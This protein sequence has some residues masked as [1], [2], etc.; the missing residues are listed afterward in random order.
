[1]TALTFRPY[2]GCLDVTLGSIR[3]AVQAV[4]MRRS[5]LREIY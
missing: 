2:P 4:Y 5:K 1:M 3:Q